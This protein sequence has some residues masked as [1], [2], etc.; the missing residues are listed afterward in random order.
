MPTYLPTVSTLE[1]VWAN[2]NIFNCGLIRL[3]KISIYGIRQRE[4]TYYKRPQYEKKKTIQRDYLGLI[5][6]KKSCRKNICKI[7]EPTTTAHEVQVPDFWKTEKRSGGVKHAC[8]WLVSTSSNRQ[9]WC[10]STTH[11]KNKL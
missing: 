1:R 4:N 11:H 10:N 9:K 5:Y 6:N 7:L 8:L 3:T 2:Q